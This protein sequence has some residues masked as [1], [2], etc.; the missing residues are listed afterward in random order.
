[1]GARSRRDRRG[2]AELIEARR[3]QALRLPDEGFSLDEVGRMLGA[4]PSR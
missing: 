3:R 2:S 4:A 1:M